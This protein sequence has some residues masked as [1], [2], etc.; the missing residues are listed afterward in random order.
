[1]PKVS[2]MGQLIYPLVGRLVPAKAEVKT[3]KEPTSKFLI[4]LSV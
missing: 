2:V 4:G 3:V 1:M